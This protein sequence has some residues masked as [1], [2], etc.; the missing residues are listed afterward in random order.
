MKFKKELDEHF[1]S[2]TVASQISESSHYYAYLAGAE[3]MLELM[4]SKTLGYFFG[5]NGAKP[6]QALK[7]FEIGNLRETLKDAETLANAERARGDFFDDNATV[8]FYSVNIKKE[9]GDAK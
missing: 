1:R 7:D 5:L 4:G 2:P 8:E 9:P 6:E 3:K